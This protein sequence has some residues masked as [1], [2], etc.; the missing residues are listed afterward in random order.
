MLTTTRAL[1]VFVLCLIASSA[2]AVPVR[3]EV[4]DGGNGHLYQLVIGVDFLSWNEARTQAQALGTGWD[5]VTLTSLEESD[6]VKSLFINNP[7]AFNPVQLGS[8]FVGPWIGGFNASDKITSPF[9]FEWVTGETVSFLD[10]G[11][12]EPFGNGQGILY[13]D[14]NAPVGDGSGIAWNDAGETLDQPFHFAYLAEVPEPSTA[15]LMG[16]GLAGLGGV[17]WRA[18]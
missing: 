10:W 12:F 9:G 5:L 15:L 8:N 1:P 18:G 13:G 14:F 3:W 11:P 7:D 16:L 6:F 4:A 2:Q 17:R